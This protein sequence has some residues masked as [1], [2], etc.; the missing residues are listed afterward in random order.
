MF[1]LNNLLLSGG[2]PVILL[3][4]FIESGFPFGFFLPGDTLLFTAG[5]FASQG[6]YPIALVISGIF[7]SNFAGVTIGYWMGKNLGKKYVK[8]ESKYLFKHKY[9]DKATAFYERHGGK[10]IILGRFVP[11]VRSF[12][13]IIAGVANMKYKSLIIYNAIGALIW[14]TSI[15]LLGFYAGSWLE[16]K[17]IS[18]DSLVLPIILLIIILSLLGPVVHA[19][20]D[21]STRDKI[22]SKLNFKHFS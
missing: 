3:V 2:L 21:K 5:L 17:G 8:Q 15:P 18:V 13:P 10:A 1:D 7:V 19:L 4:V 9:V 20:Q 22:F 14:A 6:K 11:A 16:S 12:V